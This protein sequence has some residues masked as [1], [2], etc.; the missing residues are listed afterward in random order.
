MLVDGTVALGHLLDQLGGAHEML[1]D[2][3]LYALLDETDD[4]KSRGKLVELTPPV[5]PEPSS[6]GN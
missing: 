4:Q 6:A 2:L 5:R 3:K 1:G